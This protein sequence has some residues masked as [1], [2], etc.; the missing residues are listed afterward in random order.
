MLG[1]GGCT[2]KPTGD[3]Q[4]GA[5]PPVGLYQAPNIKRYLYLVEGVHGEQ[6]HPGNV[7][8]FNDPI[9]YCGFARCASATETCSRLNDGEGTQTGSVEEQKRYTATNAA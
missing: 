4:G 8:R 2:V 7:Q 9:G 1:S 5:A 6:N 3:H